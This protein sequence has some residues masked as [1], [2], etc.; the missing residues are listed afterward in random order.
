LQEAIS[1]RADAFV[2]ADLKYHTFQ[3]GENRI[4]F[5]DAGHYETEIPA[6]NVVKR[7]LESLI[8]INGE[9]VKVVK[10][11]GSTNPVKFFNNRRS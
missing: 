4:L 6:L 5:I 10:Y 2:T 7:K 11:S 1:H 9:S 3:D 8:N